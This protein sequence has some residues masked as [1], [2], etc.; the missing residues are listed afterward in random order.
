V[1]SIDWMDDSTDGKAS[2]EC[3]VSGGGGVRLRVS[4][5]AVYG[6]KWLGWN[7]GSDARAL[8]GPGEAGI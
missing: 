8:L 6:W 5:D 2:K 7:G 4:G 3:A 1:D